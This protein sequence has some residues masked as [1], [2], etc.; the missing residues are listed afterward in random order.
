MLIHS[1]LEAI[2]EHPEDYPDYYIRNNIILYHGCVLVPNNSALHQLLISEYHTTPT[3]GH[4]GIRR[5]L[6]RISSIFVY[7]DLKKHVH[8]FVNRCSICQQNK[9][10]NHAPQGLLQPLPILG[11]VWE[12]AAMDFITHLPPSVGKTV[13]LV[14]IYRLSKQAHFS[15]IS[16]HF[17]APQVAEFFVRD[18]V[19][20]HE[21]RLPSWQ[22]ANRFSSVNFGK[23]CF[24]YRAPNSQWVAHTIRK[25]IARPRLL[26]AIWKT[27]YDA[28]RAAIL[29]LGT[30]SSHG[31][32]GTTIWPSILQFVWPFSKQDM[33]NLRPLF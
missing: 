2:T 12:S 8:V 1:L 25:Q 9:P 32:N 13:I 3:G 4:A 11:Q 30:I 16:S 15:A 20:L 33:V 28:S 19:R 23:N 31:P 22:I 26:I 24:D 29:G 6:Y 27:I 10:F 14:V 7:P 17:T 21:Y 5:I 18:I